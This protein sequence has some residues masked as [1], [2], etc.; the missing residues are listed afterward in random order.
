MLPYDFEVIVSHCEEVIE[1][2]LP[3][4]QIVMDLSLQK[5]KDVAKNIREDALVIGADTLVFLDGEILEKPKDYDDAFSMLSRLSGK[6]HTVLTGF[7]V[8]DCISQKNVTDYETTAVL[9][10]PLTE[11]QIRQYLDTEEAFDKAGAYGIQGIGSVLIQEIH[12]D[13]FNVV[14]M[15][16]SKLYDTLVKNF[17]FD[18]LRR[19]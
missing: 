9:F 19:K 2:G 1:K 7:T 6:T 5:A 18:L 10:K 17:D 15:P 13:Y 3:P 16:V 11:R 12:G 8:M 4:S 14:G